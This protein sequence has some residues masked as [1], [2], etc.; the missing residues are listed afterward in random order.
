MGVAAFV[1][2]TCERIGFPKRALEQ[3]ISAFLVSLR[4]LLVL[5]SNFSHLPI[6]FASGSGRIYTFEP[7]R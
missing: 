7:S 5:D 6:L 2:K 3:A 1:C 4:M